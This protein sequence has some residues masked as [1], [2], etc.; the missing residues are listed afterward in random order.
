MNQLTCEQVMPHMESYHRG[1]AG[2]ELTVLVEEHLARCTACRRRLAH[3]K[4]VSV[5]LSAW[6]PARAPAALKIEIAEAVGGE[7]GRRA[8]Q[9]YVARRRR[10]KKP[11]RRRSRPQLTPT[12]RVASWLVIAALLFLGAA[13]IYR[14]IET[15][16]FSSPDEVV[17]PQLRTPAES[18][19]ANEPA[20]EKD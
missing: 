16:Y 8:H 15:K 14:I 20:D 6:R 17:P 12:Q 2:Q 11:P 1:D 4:Q 5:M 10:R 7:V 19:P 9:V 3:L 18:S 13:I